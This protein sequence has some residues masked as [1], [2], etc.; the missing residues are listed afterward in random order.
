MVGMRNKLTEVQGCGIVKQ[1]LCIY[2]NRVKCCHINHILLFFLMCKKEL[3]FLLH[4]CLCVF[5]SGTS[6]GESQPNGDHTIRYSSYSHLQLSFTQFVVISS[7][8]FI[9]VHS[10]FSQA[11]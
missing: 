11:E 3:L 5:T 7:A 8:L 6:N 2:I 1:N 9:S 4:L 10:L